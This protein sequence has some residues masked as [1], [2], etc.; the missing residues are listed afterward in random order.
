MDIDRNFLNN[1]DLVLPR[2]EV[3]VPGLRKLFK[4]LPEN[5]T[6]TLTIRGLSGPEMFLAQAAVSANALRRKLMTVLSESHSEAQA[7]EQMGRILTDS[8]RES[9][10]YHQRLV[11]FRCGV[12]DGNGGPLF[13]EFETAR[14]AQFWGLTFMSVSTEILALSQE[15]PRA[16][17]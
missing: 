1:A 16:G 4:N 3:P 14:I 7:G 5:E 17:E 9:D 8:E 10:D 13:S 15:G 2:K 11:V 6:P 12:T